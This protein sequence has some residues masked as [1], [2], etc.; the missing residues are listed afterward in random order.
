MKA[1]YEAPPYQPKWLLR[2]Q[3]FLLRH[4]LMGPFN[5]QFMIITTVGR[6]SRRK[7]SIPLGFIRDGSTYL[8]FNLGGKS[9]WYKNALANPYVTLEV[10][11]RRIEACAEPVPTT[12]PVLLGQVLDAYERAHPGMFTE[13]FQLAPD[14]SQD[15]RLKIGDYAAFMRFIPIA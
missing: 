9:N 12:N 11:G 8:A 14:A 10:D 5:R 13:F 1:K 7:H 6:K 2:I 4:H 3:V 15:E